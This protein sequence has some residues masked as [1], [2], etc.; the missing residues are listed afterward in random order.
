METAAK[1]AKIVPM[2]LFH[3]PKTSEEIM[4]FIGKL[5]GNDRALATTIFGMTWNYLASVVAEEGK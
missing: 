4:D 3:T 2:G 5:R 1:K